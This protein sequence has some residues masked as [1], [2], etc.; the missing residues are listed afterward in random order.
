M[1]EGSRSK[2]EELILFIA[3][4]M[5]EDRHTGRGRI[6][7]AKLVWRSDFAAYWKFGAPITE[8]RYHA[9]EHGPAPV[10]ELLALRDLQ[11]QGR[12]E[13]R[14]EWDQE[15]V[16]VPLDDP[17]VSVFTPEQ[18]LLI[19]GQVD[20]YQYVTGRAMRDEAH[21]FPGYIHAWRDGAGKHEPVPLESVF[22]DDRKSLEAWEEEHARSLVDDLGLAR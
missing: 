17:D 7:L 3:K 14:N 4:K 11:D 21:E 1:S 12:L 10:D 19:E 16:P 9:D 22:W 13:I 20:K 18:L 15:Q 8:S 5:E 2:L 6:K